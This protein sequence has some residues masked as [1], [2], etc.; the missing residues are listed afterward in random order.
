M[1]SIVSIA[2]RHDETI[3]CPIRLSSDFGLLSPPSHMIK[4]ANGRLLSCS[5]RV[6]PFLHL[7]LRTLAEAAAHAREPV[8]AAF[9][10]QK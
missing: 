3:Q 6:S 7:T 8:P 4:P 9:I 10:I 1:S 5:G 2:E